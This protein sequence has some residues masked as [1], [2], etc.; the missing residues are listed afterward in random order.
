MPCCKRALLALLSDVAGRLDA[1]NVTYLIVFGTL[2]GAV[3]NAS[4]VPNN[5]TLD[6]DL[7]VWQPQFAQLAGGHALGSTLG[8][9][10]HRRGILLWRQ[11]GDAHALVMRACFSRHVRHP[12]LEGVAL[13]DPPTFGREGIAPWITAYEEHHKYLDL[14]EWGELPAE[15]APA[16]PSAGAARVHD[17]PGR[18]AAENVLPLQ[19]LVVDG[20]RLPVASHPEALLETWYGADWLV[21]K[22]GKHRFSAERSMGWLHG[23]TPWMLGNLLGG[24]RLANSGGGT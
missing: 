5:I 20:L 12:A 16:T 21:V 18:H 9:E 11:P 15:A 4:I 6:V 8:V 23:L 2:L 10:L 3:R 22:P 14:Y 24:A 13:R 7:A 17:D 19:H 1:H